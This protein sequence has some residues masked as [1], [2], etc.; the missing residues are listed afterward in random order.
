MLDPVSGLPSAQGLAAIEQVRT[1]SFGA[2]AII[3]PEPVAAIQVPDLVPLTVVLRQRRTVRL[4]YSCRVTKGNDA[5]KVAFRFNRNG[6]GTGFSERYSQ[7]IGE[8][9]AQEL[10]RMDLDRDLP[11]GRYTYTVV[12]RAALGVSS[13]TFQDQFFSAEV[14]NENL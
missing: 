14:I 1:S 7:S 2:S 6:D 3:N 10:T 4:M 5:D 11:P 8:I 13:T 9:S 12:H